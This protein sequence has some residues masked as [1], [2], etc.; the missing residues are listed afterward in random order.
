MSALLYVLTFNIDQDNLSGPCSVSVWWA[1]FHCTSATFP[2]RVKVCS[3]RVT[4]ELNEKTWR[5]LVFSSLIQKRSQVST[6]TRRRVNFNPIS[7]IVQSVSPVYAMCD[8]VHLPEDHPQSQPKLQTH[9]PITIIWFWTWSRL[10]I[11]LNWIYLPLFA[12]LLHVY[13]HTASHLF[14]C[15]R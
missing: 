12:L 13:L 8:V 15:S 11:R 6:T 7:D 1:V 3:T 2:F 5:L 9:Q 14:Y 10:N 4:A